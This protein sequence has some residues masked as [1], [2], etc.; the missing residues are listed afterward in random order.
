VN[1][2]NTVTFFTHPD[3]GFSTAAAAA[4]KFNPPSVANEVSSFRERRAFESL[5]QDALLAGT[6]RETFFDRQI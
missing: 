6:H 4:A 2:A 5:R 3:Q 1:H